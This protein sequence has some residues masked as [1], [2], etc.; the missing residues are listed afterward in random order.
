MKLKNNSKAVELLLESYGKDK[1]PFFTEL[2][3]KFSS[4]KYPFEEINLIKQVLFPAYWNCGI[5]ASGKNIKGLILKIEALGKQFSEG[6]SPYVEDKKEVEQIV[7]KVLENLGEVREK[8][9][10]DVEAAYI[11]DPAAKTYTEIIRSYPGF[12]AIEIHRV[13]HLLYKFGAK[14]YSREISEVIHSETG[15]DIHPGA[16]IGNYFFIDHGTG[17]V[18]GETS[19]IGDWVRIYQDVTLGVLHF[20]KEKEGDIRK[21]YKRHPD[22]GDHV[23]IGAGAKILGPVKIGNHVN[24]GANSWITEDIPDYTS[25][26]VAEHPRLEKRKKI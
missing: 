13:S 21:D 23:V 24:I 7:N 5:I 1:T 14:G 17:V 25:V 3:Q 20:E 16:K 26:F 6:I 9:K 15:I 18:I 12:L 2:T 19:V 8:L 10:K 4:R 11:G 22:I